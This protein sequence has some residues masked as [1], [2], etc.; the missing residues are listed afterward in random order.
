MMKKQVD[1]GEKV[2]KFGVEGN[3]ASNKFSMNRPRYKMTIT[4]LALSIVLFLVCI[5]IVDTS[6]KDV[7]NS[8][9]NAEYDV[10]INRR[11]GG[12]A[13]EQINKKQCEAYEKLK[14]DASK[15]RGVDKVVAISMDDS[16]KIA[17]IDMDSFTSQEKERLKA[18][19][20]DDLKG[21]FP[22]KIGTIIENIYVD[23][24]IYKEVL[25]EAGIS[26]SKYKSWDSPKGIIYNVRDIDYESEKKDKKILKDDVKIIKI[27]DYDAIYDYAEK[28]GEEYEPYY[29]IWPLDNGDLEGV[30]SSLD[31]I[32]SKEEDFEEDEELEDDVVK[33]PLFTKDLAVAGTIEKT[34]PGVRVRTPGNIYMIYP[35][36]C[37]ENL[38]NYTVAMYSDKHNINKASLDAFIEN[39]NLSGDD[40]T[41][42]KGYRIIV[43]LL[44]VF[45]GILL[46]I[47]CRIAVTNVFNIINTNSYSIKRD[48]EMAQSI[49]VL[50][51]SMVKTMVCECIRYGIKEIALGGIVGIVLQ[52][53]LCNTINWGSVVL[54]TVLVAIIVVVSMVY[55]I[56]KF[57]NNDIIEA[58][59]N[60]N[61]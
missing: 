16:Y 11:E 27:E 19:Y 48:G 21:E 17:I 55:A 59:K 61:V 47:A 10:L 1:N 36:S 54:V 26:Q 41:I 6:K 38:E 44:K 13:D 32:Y 39:N 30:P 5:V 31:I 7:T 20:K 57:K 40:T 33:V 3:C 4:S 42:T 22:E 43:F 2:R 14:N 24:N 56:R 50:Y 28:L 51:K 49:E 35:E 23:D 60:E 46:I 18:E 29:S 25:K 58:T 15:V 52:C 37:R 8:L 34:L 53:M 12:T 45:S 9:C